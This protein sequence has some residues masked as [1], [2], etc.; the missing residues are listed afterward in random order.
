MIYYLSN[1]LLTISKKTF[2]I[3]F[4]TTIIQNVISQ[5]DLKVE[6]FGTSNYMHEVKPSFFGSSEKNRVGNSKGESKVYQANISL[7]LSLS[8]NEKGQPKLWAIAFGGT[9]TNL[10]NYDFTEPHVI[11]EITNFNIGLVHVRP[12][13]EKLSLMA[14]LGGSLNMVHSNINQIS[15]NNALLNLGAV[16]IKQVNPNF[17]AGLGVAVNNT[18]G[19]PMILPVVYIKWTTQKKRFSVNFSL[20][21]GAEI[22]VKYNLNKTLNIGVIAENKGQGAFLKRNAKNVIFTHQYSTFGITPEIKLAKGL[23]MPIVVGFSSRRN[24]QFRERK[25]STLFDYK[26]SYFF[27]LAPY[28]SVRMKYNFGK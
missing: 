19:Y 22:N 13:N 25:L 11:P 14:I 24:A 18:F 7:P 10:N 8:V 20:L 6:Y 26:H 21:R 17:K 28:F 5:I 1:S 15:L 16:F 9:Y 2:C 23:S 12:L 3:F 4:F 27:D